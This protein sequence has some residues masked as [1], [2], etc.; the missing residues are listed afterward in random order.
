MLLASAPAKTWSTSAARPVGFRLGFIDDQS[1]SSEAG[2]IQGCYGF[3][4]FF[5]AGYLHESKSTG[6]PCV[7]IGH[8]AYS[9]N[10]SVWLEELAQFRFAGAVRQIS[11][12]NVLHSNPS[13]DSPIANSETSARFDSRT[14]RSRGGVGRLRIAVV[15]A[16]ATDRT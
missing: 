11:H 5:I 2:T 13:F 14:S 12:V 7:A 16:D 6:A 1:A 15:R 10:A 4:S 9:L 8:H 3:F